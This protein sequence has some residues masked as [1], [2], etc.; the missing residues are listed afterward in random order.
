MR[1]TIDLYSGEKVSDVRPT[2]AHQGENVRKPHVEGLKLSVGFENRKTMCG[3]E[4]ML[5]RL[6][7]SR[8]DKGEGEWMNS[9][10]WRIGSVARVVETMNKV[11]YGLV[12]VYQY[13]EAEKLGG[14]ELDNLNVINIAASSASTE[15][16]QSWIAACGCTVFASY[17]HLTSLPTHRIQM[18]M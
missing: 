6:R 3:D 7:A 5:C 4:T 13:H 9:K 8:V 1:T 12:V 14:H 2:C 11:I 10:T 17:E 15:Q 18:P 16:R